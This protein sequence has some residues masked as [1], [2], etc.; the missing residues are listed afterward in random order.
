[1]FKSGK[2][3]LSLLFALAFV[4]FSFPLT[5][6]A[7][8]EASAQSKGE[9]IEYAENPESAGKDESN[10]ESTQYEKG[11]SLGVFQLVGYSGDG[12]TYSGAPTKA[13]H[14]IA[15]DLTVLPLGTKV[16]VGDTVYTVEDIGSAVKGKM[17]D[18]YFSTME[19][20]K[21]LTK[22]GRVYSEVFVALPKR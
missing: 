6:F 5:A 7:E 14:T 11:E 15:A 16:F 10:T 21:N 17:I 13:Q 4:I 22:S 20:A 2:G 12:M 1:M 9:V 8:G 18:I 3:K 19:E